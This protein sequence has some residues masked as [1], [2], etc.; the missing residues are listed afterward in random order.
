MIYTIIAAFILVLVG[1]I[2]FGPK[3]LIRNFSKK[4]KS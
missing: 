3:V 4:R 2:V 1:F